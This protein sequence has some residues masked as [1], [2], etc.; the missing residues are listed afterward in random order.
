VIMKEQKVSSRDA[1]G[2][3]LPPRSHASRTAG[4]MAEPGCRR[5]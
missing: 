3:S 2:E 5:A 1:G 4:E